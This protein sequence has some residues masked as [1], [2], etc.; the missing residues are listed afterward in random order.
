MVGV[1][2]MATI[3]IVV[4]LCAMLKGQKLLALFLSLFAF[5]FA[6]EVVIGTYG[7]TIT[8]IAI[9]LLAALIASLLIQFA[10]KLA[11]FLLG[12]IAGIFLAFMAIPM[13]TFIPVEYHWIAIIITGILFGILTAHFNKVFIRLATSFIGGRIFSIGALFLI[14]NATNL[15]NFATNDIPTD[16]QN[17]LNY[18]LTT[19]SINNSTYIL[20]ASLLFTI[21]GYYFQAKR[22]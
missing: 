5:Y 1:I 22:H 8:T 13:L 9:A 7:N 3:M 11:F 21:I 17:T 16:L 15:S 6:F 19:F 12:F 10:Q 20:I 14:F 18:M 4:G 2:L